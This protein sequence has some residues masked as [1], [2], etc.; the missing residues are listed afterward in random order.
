MMQ[1]KQEANLSSAGALKLYKHTSCSLYW[2]RSDSCGW[3]WLWLYHMSSKIFKGTTAPCGVQWGSPVNSTT[4]SI[5]LAEW[6]G[7]RLTPG[8]AS[9]PHWWCQRSFK[10][11]PLQIRFMFLFLLLRSAFNQKSLSGTQRPCDMWPWVRSQTNLHFTH[12]LS[13]TT[14]SIRVKFL[15]AATKRFWLCS[16]LYQDRWSDGSVH[17]PKRGSLSCL[18][19]PTNSPKP[20]DFSFAV[21]NDK[22]KLQIWTFKQLKLSK[23]FLFKKKTFFHLTPGIINKSQQLHTE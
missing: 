16:K 21:R 6:R 7:C 10:E 3:K 1:Q 22:G 23:T 5:S 4:T 14:A 9:V 8:S 20:K 11:T 18:F 2:N 15:L 19:S 12:L 17:V 13:C